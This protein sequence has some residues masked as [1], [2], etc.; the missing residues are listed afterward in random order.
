MTYTIQFYK[1]PSGRWFFDDEAKGIFHEEMVE[2]V[3]EILNFYA[4][5]DADTVDI[6]FSDAPFNGYDAKLVFLEEVDGGAP[7]YGGVIYGD[8]DG[9]STLGTGWFCPTFWKYFDKP[10]PRYLY[11]KVL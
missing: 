4:G 10:A 11:F 9:V 3:P 7:P 6:T 2:G 1:E 8:F 5:W